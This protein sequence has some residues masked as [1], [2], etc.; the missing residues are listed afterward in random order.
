MRIIPTTADT[1]LKTIFLFGGSFKN[2]IARY[3]AIIGLTAV[4]GVAI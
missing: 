2:A 4:M 3:E 1:K